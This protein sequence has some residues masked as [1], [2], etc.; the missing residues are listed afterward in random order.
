MTAVFRAD[1]RRR[2]TAVFD[3]VEATL[4]RGLVAQLV[5][6]VEDGLPASSEPVQ[7]WAVELGLEDVGVAGPTAA[8]EDPVLR[9]LLPD[10]YAPPGSPAAQVG[11][12]VGPEVDAPVG[13]PG[14]DEIVER[15]AEFRRLTENGLRRKKTSRARL[16]LDALGRPEAVPGDHRAAGHETE[17]DAPRHAGAAG[18]EGAE[19]AEGWDAVAEGEEPV[20]VRLEPPTAQAWLTVLT[21]LR[22]AL[23]TR[24]GIETEEDSAELEVLAQRALAHTRRRQRRGR[25]RADAGDR[26]AA[27][28]DPRIGV[29]QVYSWLGYLQESLV[30]ALS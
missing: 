27:V 1:R 22:L 20:T 26:A 17:P 29:Y 5:E 28:E 9:R 6:L 16:V 13:A 3:P 23:A 21:D 8:P 10:G 11:P 25:G 7:S 24:L 30:Q 4:L 19:G 18:V 2:P 15:A 12:Q 14:P